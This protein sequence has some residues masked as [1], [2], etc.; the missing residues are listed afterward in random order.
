MTTWQIL[1]CQPIMWPSKNAS[2]GPRVIISASY[3]SD[4][5]YCGLSKLGYFSLP[6]APMSL[7]STPPDR[8]S[9]DFWAVAAWPGL[10]RSSGPS[11]SCTRSCPRTDL[12]SGRVTAP[13]PLSL[14]VKYEDVI[15]AHPHQSLSTLSD[16]AGPKQMLWTSSCPF[17]NAAVGHTGEGGGGGEG[18][19]GAH[20]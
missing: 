18:G 20:S 16:S 1:L 11:S 9:S 3:N 7:R 19:E 15:N 10:L 14:A 2:V 17:V 8:P 4:L 5:K 12:V 13:P 6:S